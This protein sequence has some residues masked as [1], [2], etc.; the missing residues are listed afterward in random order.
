MNRHFDSTLFNQT[1]RAGLFPLFRKVRGA[2]RRDVTK[3]IRSGCPSP[4]PHQVKMD[5]VKSYINRTNSSIFVE[6]GTFT[7]ATLDYIA[8]MKGVT[9]YS[10]EIDK[11]YHERAQVI[12][13]GRV[14][15]NLILG[16]SSLELSKL[17]EK[18]EQPAVFW[19]DAHYSG[20]L[21]GRGDLDSPISAEL[22]AILDHPIK[23]HVILIDDARDFNGTDGYPFLSDVLA[24]FNDH[25][26]YQAEVS[27]DIIR[28]TPRLG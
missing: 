8:R 11:S 1:Q 16:D 6:T 3:W 18:I 21:T 20:G 10:I 12:L 25:S 22:G 24:T 2:L 7:G 19:L 5:I 28:I 13:G 4:A 23:R 26:H 14:N 15:I 27:A 9:C 17:L